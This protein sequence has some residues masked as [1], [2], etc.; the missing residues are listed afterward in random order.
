MTKK[1]NSILLVLF[2]LGGVVVFL[3][4]VMMVVLRF[5]GPSSGLAFGEKIGVIPIHGTILNA[6]PILSQLVAFKKDKRIKAI[7]L[8]IDSPGGGVGASQEIYREIRKTISVKKIVVSM[9]GV[10]ASGGYY[11]A[12]AADRIVANP[13][14]ITG[15]IGVIM[16]FIQ[17][18]ELLQKIGI[19][20]EVIKSGEYKDVGSPHRKLSERER[21]LMNRLILDIQEQFVDA[22]VDGR[23]LEKEAVQ[24]IADGRILSG[25]MAKDLGLVDQL[26]NF[27]DAVALA[28][29][30]GGIK[31]EAGLVYPAR[32]RVGLLDIIFQK[33]SQALYGNIVRRTVPR[34][35]Y[36]W[37]GLS[38]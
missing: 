12:A 31:G 27:Q 30:M 32:P 2:I 8:R 14:T 7:I 19:S 6:E 33:A 26:G 11:I 25:A 13:G 22:V 36:L 35:E 20:L 3:A 4:M 9:G 5:M 1:K 24:A 16:E 18:E 23:G 15:S 34:L 21:D 37:S 28:K 29:K 17:M 10:A 38:Y